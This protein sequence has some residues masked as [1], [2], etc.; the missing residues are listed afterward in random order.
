VVAEVDPDFDAPWQLICEACPKREGDLS[1]AEL[2]PLF[3]RL[4]VRGLGLVAFN[5]SHLSMLK[6]LLE[7][8]VDE[9]DP[10][11]WY[12]TYAHREWLLKK[13]RPA[14]LKAIGA[15]LSENL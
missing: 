1:W 3:F 4:D 9:A 8:T 6:S 12:Q 13:N 5:R 2:P 11:A 14:L 15:A 10:Y 7:G